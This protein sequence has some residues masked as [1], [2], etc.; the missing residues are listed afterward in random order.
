MASRKA[1]ETWESIGDAEREAWVRG[2][3][4]DMVRANE[5]WRP[6][7]SCAWELRYAGLA[8]LPGPVR[9]TCG[10][11]WGPRGLWGDR[12]RINED[13]TAWRKNAR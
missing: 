12:T 7:H 5:Y 4:A 11:L 13:G 1:G 10:A 3:E 6:A 2:A 9:C 8:G